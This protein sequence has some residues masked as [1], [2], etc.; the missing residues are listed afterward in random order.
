MAALC[1]FDFVGNQAINQ[2]STWTRVIYL[3]DDVQVVT[4]GASTSGGRFRLGWRGGWTEEIDYNASAAAM[5]AM[6]ERVFGPGMVDVSGS[7]P[8]S[9]TPNGLIYAKYGHYLLD[10]DGAGLNSFSGSVGVKWNPVD[11]TGYS[12]RMQ[13][14]SE[15]DSP[16][17]YVSLTEGSGMTTGTSD[18]TITVS[19]AVSATLAYGWTR[20][21]YDIETVAAG[22]DVTRTHEGWIEVSRESTR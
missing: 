20:G 5:E 12:S 16:N 15:P 11:L 18:G 14:R 19:I 1:R 6:L 2:G 10:V 22:G 7:N 13:I 17:T 9:I 3:T 4:L 8:W 21:W